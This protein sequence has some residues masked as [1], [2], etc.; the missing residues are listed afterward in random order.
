M[1]HTEQRMRSKAERIERLRERIKQ[2]GM[3]AD[4]RGVLLGVLDL[5]ADEL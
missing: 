3:P 1:A 2:S 5:L 4:L